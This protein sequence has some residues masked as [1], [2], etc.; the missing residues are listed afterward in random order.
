LPAGWVV[1][2]LTRAPGARF[3]RQKA[4]RSAGYGWQI[5][6]GVGPRIA[7]VIVAETGGD[8]ACFTSSARLACDPVRALDRSRRASPDTLG[9]KGQ[10][11]AARNRPPRPGWQARPWSLKK[12]SLR[13]G[14]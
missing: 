2:R 13:C 11:P 7:Q 14:P 3:H 5:T 8:M 12:A 9:E 10:D 6:P 1:A 4:A